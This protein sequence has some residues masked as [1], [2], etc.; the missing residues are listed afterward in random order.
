MLVN[1]VITIG[2]AMITFDPS[3]TGPLRF[4]DSFRKKVGGAELNFAI[5]CSRL[6]LPISLISRLGKDEFGRFIYN[7]IRGEGVDV[8]EIKLVEGYSTS[9]NF[10]EIKEGGSSETFYYR[11]NSPTLTLT[12]GSLNEKLFEKS[13]LLHISGVFPSI[14]KQNIETVDK[15]IQKAKR[16]DLKISLDPN[17]R[18]KMWDKN[19]ARETLLRW[20]RDVDYLLA[21]IDEAELLFDT[22]EMSELIEHA[23]EYSISN[24]FIKLG[25]KGA[26]LWTNGKLFEAPSANT[27]KV[28]DEVGAGDGFDVGAIYGLLNNWEPEKILNFANTI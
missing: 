7:F 16:H 6:G 5:G 11:Y 25:G 22:R 12:P 4:V 19:K 18:F 24:L 28:V 15:A 2:D 20:M 14:H 3:N 9:L 21:G 17:I 23:K 27:L 13:R 10:K 1:D 26:N 8:S